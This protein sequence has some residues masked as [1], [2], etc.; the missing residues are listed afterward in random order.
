MIRKKNPSSG[1]DKL[2][3]SI[4][5][6]R[7]VVEAFPLQKVVEI[8]EEVVVGWQEVKG[9]WQMRQN[10]VAQFFQLLKSWSCDVWL[11][12]AMENWALSV[13]QLQACGFQCI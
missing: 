8:L 7:L 9:I 11:G 4:F 12:I 6:L 5:C 3:E 2:L 1:F 13:D 10:L